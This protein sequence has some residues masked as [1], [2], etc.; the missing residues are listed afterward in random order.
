M[1]WVTL[2]RLANATWLSWS[3]LRSAITRCAQSGVVRIPAPPLDK[4]NRGLYNLRLYELYAQ[5]PPYTE[6]KVSSTGFR[7]QVLAFWSPWPKMME[8]SGTL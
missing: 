7:V 8:Q 6:A 4:N 2:N 3:S 5:G 1:V